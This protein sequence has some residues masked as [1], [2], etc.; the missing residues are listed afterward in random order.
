MQ[1]LS[2]FLDHISLTIQRLQLVDIVIA[3]LDV[4]D[5]T[6][7]PR[8]HGGFSYIGMLQAQIVPKFMKRRPV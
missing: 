7:V 5:I 4:R 1:S 2:F 3:K 6:F 8:V